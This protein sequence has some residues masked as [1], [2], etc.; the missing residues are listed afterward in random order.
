MVV[1]NNMDLQGMYFHKCMGFWFQGLLQSEVEGVDSEKL[2]FY[3]RCGLHATFPKS[4]SG[5]NSSATKMDCMV[6]RE[7]TCA[8]T[9]VL[10]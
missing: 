7:S 10:C 1:I 5:G 4:K 3:G 9:E 8:R 6:E 2:G